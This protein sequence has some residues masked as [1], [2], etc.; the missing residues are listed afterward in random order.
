ML[1][2]WDF[3]TVQAC[4]HLSFFFFG[5]SHMH[6]L[7][8]SCHRHALWLIS[9]ISALVCESKVSLARTVTRL[10]AR[11]Q[12][13]ARGAWSGT[14]LRGDVAWSEFRLQTEPPFK[15]DPPPSPRALLTRFCVEITSSGLHWTGVF[16]IL[17]GDLLETPNLLLCWSW[18]DKLHKHWF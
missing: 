6:D 2:S 10:R 16:L 13:L 18:L 14:C 9:V 17:H 15:P 7:W 12:H 8:P 3:S 5:D 11:C 1:L 4:L